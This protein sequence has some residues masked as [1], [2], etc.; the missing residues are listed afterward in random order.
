MEDLQD[1][2]VRVLDT[3]VSGCISQQ[4]AWDTLIDLD[5]IDNTMDKEYF[6]KTYLK[7]IKEY[8]EI[9]L[10]IVDTVYYLKKNN[11]ELKTCEVSIYLPVEK[12]INFIVENELIPFSTVIGSN[13]DTVMHYIVLCK[14]KTGIEDAEIGDFLIKNND[15]KTPLDY[16]S[17]N[18][19]EILTEIIEKLCD[20]NDKLEHDI[21][22]IQNE[23]YL[24]KNCLKFI[25]KK[26]ESPF[27]YYIISFILG[28]MVKFLFD[29]IF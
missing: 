15:G 19:K 20:R 16:V 23:L 17:I 11:C 7:V 14:N 12:L 6:I 5:L 4:D 22:E 25:S 2:I 10:Q 8:N 28:M 26:F 24:N 3:S 1:N 9:D 29:K 18:E 27:K 13:G 21:K